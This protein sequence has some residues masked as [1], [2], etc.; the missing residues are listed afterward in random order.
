ML[1]SIDLNWHTF[2]SMT[3]T[4]LFMLISSLVIGIFFGLLTSFIMKSLPSLKLNKSREVLFLILCAYLSYM[5]AEYFNFSGI[6]TIFICGITLSQY[7]YYNLSVPS[8]KASQLE[9]PLQNSL[10][11]D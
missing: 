5:V 1:N 10:A 7:A 6:I 9:D 3:F 11:A 4:F 8:R 2:S